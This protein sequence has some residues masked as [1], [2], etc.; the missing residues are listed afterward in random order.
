MI[1]P[2]Q[3]GKLIAELEKCPLDWPV[4]FDF[5]QCVPTSLASYRRFYDHLAIGFETDG[6]MTVEA[7]LAD[8]RRAI[9]GVFDGYKGGEYTMTEN[10]PV[11]VANWGRYTQTAIVAVRRTS[12][13]V[14]LETASTAD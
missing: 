11:W 9:G 8:L 5:C 10:T 13:C 4:Y 12:F 7:L 14:L 6:Q 3:L 2:M 1:E